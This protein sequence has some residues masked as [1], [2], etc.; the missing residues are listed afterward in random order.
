MTGSA[1]ASHSLWAVTVSLLAMLAHAANA[2][3]FVL[4]N[5][6]PQCF[7]PFCGKYE[8]QLIWKFSNAEYMWGLL[9][10]P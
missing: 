9:T 10:C 1:R 5:L 6:F 8:I 7:V 3:L 2:V 4:L